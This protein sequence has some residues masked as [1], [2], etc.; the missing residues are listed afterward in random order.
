LRRFSLGICDA[1]SYEQN[2]LRIISGTFFHKKM[3]DEHLSYFLNNKKITTYSSRF[4]LIIFEIPSF[5][6][7]HCHVH[8]PLRSHCST[9]LPQRGR[10]CGTL[11]VDGTCAWAP[12]VTQARPPASCTASSGSAAWGAGGRVAVDTA[13]NMIIDGSR[14][15]V[16]VRAVI[17][18]FGARRSIFNFDVFN[19]GSKNVGPKCWTHPP[20]QRV[21]IGR[22]ARMVGVGLGPRPSLPPSVSR[23]AAGCRSWR[24]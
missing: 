13:N 9:R 7:A 19:T 24:V 1:K 6:W 3:I 5:I 11:G 10:S 12:C 2:S 16:R 17:W 23:L 18:F 21:P 20:A 14:V 8:S 22:C 4:S 15:H